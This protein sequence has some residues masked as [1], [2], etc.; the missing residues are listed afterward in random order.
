MISPKPSL[1]VL[2]WRYEEPRHPARGWVTKLLLEKVGPF[3][4]GERQG[5]LFSPIRY[6]AMV[7]R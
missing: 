2:G 1:L 4:L 3:A 5:D 7:A 6:F